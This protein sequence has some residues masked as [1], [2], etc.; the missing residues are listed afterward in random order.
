MS[1]Y[2]DNCVCGS[3]SALTSALHR[4][5]RIGV[6]ASSSARARIYGGS[7]PDAPN[8]ERQSFVR[9]RS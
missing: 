6:M 9:D 7:Q 3:P 2:R 4:P 5:Q 1:Y 8:G